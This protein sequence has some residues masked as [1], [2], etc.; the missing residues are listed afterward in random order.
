VLKEWVG[1]RNGWALGVKMSAQMLPPL[2][3]IPNSLHTQG[4]SSDEKRFEP[5]GAVG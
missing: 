5:A 4:L 2:P 3:R 1:P